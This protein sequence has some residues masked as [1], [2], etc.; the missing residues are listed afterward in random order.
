MK[1]SI[2]NKI[3]NRLRPEGESKGETGR[4]DAT[5]LLIL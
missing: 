2:I 3:S 1:F 4:D 5:K